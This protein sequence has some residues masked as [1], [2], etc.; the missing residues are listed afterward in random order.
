VGFLPAECCR[1]SIASDLIMTCVKYHFAAALLGISIVALMCSGCRQE[2]T[3]TNPPVTAKHEVSPQ[4]S[5]EEIANLFAESIQTGAGGVDA[6]FIVKKS[7]GHSRLAIRNDV[8]HEF[9]PP[10]QE[11]EP[12]RGVITVTSQRDFSIQRIAHNGNSDADAR[13]ENQGS[14]RRRS[15]DSD[16]VNVIDPDLVQAPAI[17]RRPEPEETEDLI[18][19]HTDEDVRQYELEYLNNRWVL[20][21]ELDPETERSIAFAFNHI[22]SLQP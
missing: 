17:D 12:Y 16:G 5:F 6:G 3:A 10:T 22:L 9:I 7:D 1:L 2:T 20:K 14:Q 4:Q 21:T 11:G 18:A 15:G 13:D 19:R 8:T